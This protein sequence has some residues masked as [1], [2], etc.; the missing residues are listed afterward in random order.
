MKRP[1]SLCA[2]LAALLI[3]SAT[4]PRAS[5]V[6]VTYFNFNDS[7]Q[8]SDLPGVQ[9]STITEPIPNGLNAS[10]VTPGSTLNIAPGDPSV[11]PNMALRLTDAN[12]GGGNP[13]TFRFS[14]T[15]LGLMNLALSYAT[16]ASIANFTQTLS[17]SINGGTTFVQIGT[18]IPTTTG[19]T[20]ATF[21][22]SGFT[23]LNNQANVIFQIELTQPGG[24]KGDYNDFD[25]IQLNATPVPEPATVTGGALALAALGYMQRHRVRALFRATRKK[26]G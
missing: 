4:A 19:F 3:F 7:N 16:Q 5:A 10:F 26:P 2:A 24:L 12:N 22:L 8:T 15:T 13:K 9:V 23:A 1:L 25:N 6:L 14:V 21:D 20:T 11:L 17:Y 18:Y